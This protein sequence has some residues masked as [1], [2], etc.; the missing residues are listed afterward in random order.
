M[1]YC[2]YLRLRNEPIDEQNSYVPVAISDDKEKLS[3][4]IDKFILDEPVCA[5]DNSEE[6]IYFE[7]GPLYKFVKPICNGINSCGVSEGIVGILSRKEVVKKAGQIA[8]KQY[9]TYYQHSLK[10]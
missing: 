6:F 8:A 1:S 4:L 7:R 9:K 3:G 10:L 5:A 2:L